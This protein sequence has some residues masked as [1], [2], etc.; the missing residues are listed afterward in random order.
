MKYP[1]SIVGLMS[2]CLIAKAQS[3]SSL[4]TL[5]SVTIHLKSPGAPTSS[6][7]SHFEIIDQRADT[8][9]IGL[10][11][12]IPTLG[13]SRPRKFIF[14]HP[15]ASEIAAWLNKNFI[16]PDAGWSALIVLRNLWLSD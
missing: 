7:F 6:A 12:F 3:T 11:T 9:L 13:H 8:T 16:R 14:Q 10:H 4:S 2:L 1:I 15:A 5:P